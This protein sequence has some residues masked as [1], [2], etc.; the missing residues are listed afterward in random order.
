MKK[1]GFFII[2]LSLATMNFGF[3]GT[4]KIEDTIAHS[5]G[6]QIQEHVKYPDFTSQMGI[7]ESS[8]VRFRVEDDYTISVVSVSGR[9]SRINQYVRGELQKKKVDVPQDGIG[10]IYEVTIKFY[11]I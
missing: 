4:E 10:K 3:A 5:L 2:M 6:K 7:E 11:V 8:I 9:N 1:L